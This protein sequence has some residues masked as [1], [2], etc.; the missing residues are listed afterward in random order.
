[1]ARGQAVRS[2]RGRAT[3]KTNSV[4]AP[5]GGLNAVDSIAAMP[6]TDALILDNFFPQPTYVSLRNGYVN[7]STGLPGWVESLFPYANNTGT[8]QLFAASGTSFYNC[9]TQG[10]VGAAVVT[11]LTNAR[12]ES[13]NVGTP[14]GAFLYTA[15]GVDS[16]RLYNGSTWT[17]ITG[18]STPAITGVTTTLLRNPEVWKNRVWFIENN[19]NRA[20]YLPVQSI[21]GVAHSLDLSTQFRLGGYLQAIMTFSVSS[22]NSFDDYIG[23]LSS[24][25]EL[26][27]YA[28]TDPDTAGAFTITGI[29]R[30]GKPLG[31]R[32][33]FKYG[34]DAVIICSDG[35]VSVTKLIS[36]GIQQ[37][38]DAISYKILQLVN[39]DVQAYSTNFGWE[40]TVYPLGNKIIINVPE[41]TN[42]RMHQYVQNTINSS[43]C[44]YGFISSPWNAATF[45][46][47]GDK[48]YYGGN[49]IVA[50]C[51]TG[52]NDSSAQILGTMKPAFSYVGTDHQ[53]RFTMVRPLI[54]TTGLVS[55]TLALNVDFQNTLPTGV[56]TFSTT[57]DSM[58]NVALWNVSF[59]SIGPIIQKDWQTVYGI[60]FSATVYMTL[61]ST[62]SA[63]N[64]LSFDYVLEAGSGIL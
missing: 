31:R 14:G 60:G 13:I 32:C 52:A 59:W 20:W 26:A 64:V 42:S 28:G 30:L 56:P 10:A 41:N 27:V 4:P 55:P 51:D 8:E 36:V 40:G 38:Q 11:G 12:W 53:K 63:V 54:Q 35:F 15:N 58:W 29:Y 57:Q 62:V 2:T 24:E 39:Q 45:C 6:V 19:S 37:P 1:M 9:T 23:F 47:L 49:T 43:W 18:V 50:Q 46:V 7:Q 16:P 5:I 22:A 33:W 34:A 48:L 3:S 44:T 17:A 25:G 61:A 21:G